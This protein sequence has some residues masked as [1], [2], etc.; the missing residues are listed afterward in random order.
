M[1]ICKSVRAVEAT[2]AAGVLAVLL[3]GCDDAPTPP[4][5][6]AYSFT[7]GGVEYRGIPDGWESRSSV[8]A[9]ETDGRIV[10]TTVAAAP[11]GVEM[12]VTETLYRDLPIVEWTLAF[13]NKGGKPSARFTRIA[14]GD[15][16]LAWPADAELTLWRGLGESLQMPRPADDA[17]NYS[18][19]RCRMATGDVQRMGP[20]G[21]FPNWMAFPYFRVASPTN[22]YT[23]AIGWQG[24]WTAEVARVSSAVRIE[25]RQA[26]VDFTLKPGEKAIAPTVTVMAFTD[27][28]DAVNG[29][30][31]FMRRYILPRAKDGVRPIRPVL[32]LDGDWCGGILY[33]KML[34]KRHLEQIR[35]VHEKGLRFDIWWVDAGWYQR[36]AGK[37]AK[38]F[39]HTW[40]S[41]V[42][43]WTCDPARFESGSFAKISEALAECGAVLTLWHEPERIS[44]RCGQEAFARA[45]PYL[46]EGGNELCRRYDLTR[47]ETVDFLVKTVGGSIRDNK[48]GFYR[49][50]CN[51]TVMDGWLDLERQRG[52]GN[53]GLVEN[54]FIQGRFRLWEGFRKVNPDMYFDICAGGGR[55]NDLSTLR[56]PA[57][58]LHYTDIGYTNHVMKCRYHHMCHEW[59]FFRKDLDSFYHTKVVDGVRMIDRR[60]AV[61]D[62]AEQHMTKASYFIDG[63]V[64]EREERA[65]I[66]AWRQVAD[67]LV[68]GDYYLLTPEVF[69][70]DRW[71]VTEFR[72]PDGDDG[73]LQVVRNPKSADATCR[74]TLR[75][76]TKGAALVCRDLF[77]GETFTAT[78]GEPLALSLPAGDGTL[79]KFERR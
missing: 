13:E 71:W 77:S 32:G 78:G 66:D 51:Q 8:A 50:D 25:A 31:R 2:V 34:E 39:N 73:F 22:G 58:P 24:Q 36:L 40:Y 75:G 12:S 59:L 54:Q 23:V 47:P 55:R 56:F 27:H 62:L 57:V 1:E 74:V 44:E 37:D 42:G 65:F 46:V 79:I 60:K 72:N 4:V 53:R 10:R 63:N 19:T 5:E 26:T 20:K 18:Y 67:Y 17:G 48:V 43:D 30:R 45:K 61:I 6:P 16:S 69:G 9:S 15:F 38:G 3:A 68:D 64:H 49:E 35:K 76:V 52:D 11:D 21:G 41:E 70:E 29:W 7:Y 14:P 33:G 28:D